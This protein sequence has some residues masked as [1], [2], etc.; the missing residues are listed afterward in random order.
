[1]SAGVLESTMIELKPLNNPSE[2]CDPLLSACLNV[3]NDA[4]AL[5]CSDGSVLFKNILFNTWFKTGEGI[6]ISQVTGLANRELVDRFL[7]VRGGD[8]IELEL[9]INTPPINAVDYKGSP[10]AQQNITCKARRLDLNISDL[11]GVSYIFVFTDVTSKKTVQK[12]YIEAQNAKR[13]TLH[14]LSHDLR[15]PMVSI[16]AV[17][18]MYLHKEKRNESAQDF[19]V[20][21]KIRSYVKKNLDYSEG[22]LLI[23]RAE[24]L[25]VDNFTLIDFHALVDSA[26]YQVKSLATHKN[27]AIKITMCEDDLWVMGSIDLLERVLINLLSNAIKYSADC[28]CVDL[29][30][31]RVGDELDVHV[32]DY[33]L[34]ISQENIEKLFTRFSCMDENVSTR[35]LGLGLFF[36]KTVIDKHHGRVDVISKLH[37][38]SS[39]NIRIPLITESLA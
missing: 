15:S 33:G 10:P 37:F 9:T 7:S 20:F 16:L 1:M 23:S 24:S 18:D 38:G 19:T 2:F 35:G 29:V 5:V 4:V 34:G 27:M 39:F 26:V 36:V 32:Q 21:E 22:L 17:I 8:C 6:H 12:S 31:Q 11:R 13:E 28:S 25:V 3:V 14:F 30:L